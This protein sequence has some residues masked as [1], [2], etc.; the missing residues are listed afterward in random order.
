MVAAERDLVYVLGVAAAAKR[1]HHAGRA[2]AIELEHI[3]RP[4]ELP[5]K[6]E[7]KR[8]ELAH[9]GA[10]RKLLRR[11][12]ALHPQPRLRQIPHVPSGIC[13]KLPH[14]RRHEDRVAGIVARAV[15]PRCSLLCGR[16]GNAPRAVSGRAPLQQQ[17][18][19]AIMPR[20][21]GL[22]RCRK[23]LCRGLVHPPVHPVCAWRP[24]GSSDQHPLAPQT[25]MPCTYCG[26]TG[27]QPHAFLLDRP[28]SRSK[29]QDE[30][31]NEPAAGPDGSFQSAPRCAALGAV[32]CSRRAR[33]CAVG[34]RDVRRAAT[35][36][37]LPSQTPGRLAPART[38]IVRHAPARAPSNPRPQARLRTLRPVAGSV[39]ARHA[40]SSTSV[41]HARMIRACCS[42][43]GLI[44][45]RPP[46]SSVHTAAD[47]G[48]GI[49]AARG[50]PRRLGNVPLPVGAILAVPPRLAGR[51]RR[52]DRPQA[53][54]AA[55]APRRRHPRMRSRT[56][57]RALAA[58]GSA[59]GAS[60]RRPQPSAHTAGRLRCGAARLHAPRRRSTPL[61]QRLALRGHP[62]I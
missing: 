27:L 43:V 56:P 37:P 18:L 55:L 29:P 13:R 11:C 15:Q 23:P 54:R 12:H 57:C 32:P 46:R 17:I 5:V 31:A 53:R 16:R 48:A 2:D 58:A 26:T 21:L 42:L 52:R 19:A 28:H 4:P 14:A 24:L 33:P 25:G 41:V 38:R 36:C 50:A 39:A 30:H 22:R 7:P 8:H 1:L 6:V 9:R 49:A 59:G 35:H 10:H 3:L 20:K 45:R 61:A 44:L 60:A 47:R 40:A 34:V 62:R 51:R